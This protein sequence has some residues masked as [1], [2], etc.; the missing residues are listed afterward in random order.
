MKTIPFINLQLDPLK[1]SWKQD[2]LSGF[3]LFLIALPLSVGISLA[4]GAPATAGILSAI[5]GGILGTFLSGGH[6]M[7][8]GPAAG[9]IVVVLT[10]VQELGKGNNELG[11]KLT[12]AAIV[13][14]GIIQ[15]L[16]G[17]PLFFGSS[18]LRTSLSLIT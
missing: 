11:F 17:L 15:I 9:L 8:N 18:S 7:I 13:C 4:S 12:L 5:V 6:V 2:L 3:I 10:S 14:A 1:H 16:L